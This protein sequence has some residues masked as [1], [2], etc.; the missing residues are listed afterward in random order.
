MPRALEARERQGQL[1]VEGGHDDLFQQMP[2]LC[3]IML[4][5]Y[6]TPQRRETKTRPYKK[7]KIQEKRMIATHP[8]TPNPQLIRSKCF[9]YLKISPHKTS[10]GFNALNNSISNL[11]FES[12]NRHAILS[13]AMTLNT[14]AIYDSIKSSIEI[15]NELKSLNT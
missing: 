8:T 2:F 4:F 1:D 14:V 11:P 13:I 9:R 3:F 5:H 6:A 10:S 12:N 15:P 7:T